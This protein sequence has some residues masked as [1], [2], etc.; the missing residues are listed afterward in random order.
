M[1]ASHTLDI[2]AP[3]V[4]W[5]THCGF[6]LAGFGLSVWAPLIPYVRERIPMSDATFGLLLLCVGAGSLSCMPLSGMLAARLGIRLASLGS[7][8]L[9]IC[10]LAIMALTDS[11]AWLGVALFAFGG[12]L[13]VL[14]IL[15]NIQSL[16]VERALQRPLMS[17][18]HGMFSLGTI[19]GAACLTALLTLGLSPALSTLLLVGLILVTT[20]A[21]RSGLLPDRAPAGGV[22]FARPTGV[23]LVVGLLCFVVYLAEGAILDWS[24]IYLTQETGMAMSL[25]GLGYASFAALV[26]IARLAGGPVVAR[27]GTVRVVVIGSVLAATGLLLSLLASHWIVAL[28]GYALCGLGCANI[29]PVLIS[30]LNHQKDMPVHLA[31]TAAT[32]VGFAGVLAGPALMGFVAHH[33]S[34]TIAFAMVAA[35]LL[36]MLFS[37]T[38]L[39]R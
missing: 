13:G 18:F 15:L 11:I 16:K 2:R 1:S 38:R 3:R 31:V 23:V 14:D 28:I 12:T 20:L 34:L 25:A 36:G 39:P 9:L 10:A 6:F 30:S 29:S 7:L 8:A 27:L 26:A 22:M 17:Q 21:I 19:A 37:T 5:A 4:R 32:T 33:S 24:A 35:L